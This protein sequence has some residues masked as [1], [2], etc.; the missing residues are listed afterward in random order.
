MTTL[1]KRLAREAAP[2][3]AD[4]NGNGFIGMDCECHLR[5]AIEAAIEDAIRAC[6]KAAGEYNGAGYR[7]RALLTDDV[8]DGG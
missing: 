7:V 6:A 5:P 2:C 8:E 4:H 1:A 3:S